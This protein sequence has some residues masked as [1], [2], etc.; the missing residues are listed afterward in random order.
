MLPLSCSASKLEAVVASLTK[1]SPNSLW[2]VER[3]SKKR[4]KNK[5]K[6]TKPNTEWKS[7]EKTKSSQ[8]PSLKKSTQVNLDKAKSQEKQV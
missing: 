7:V 5:A 3:I 1:L 2:T 6:M 4:T 8:S